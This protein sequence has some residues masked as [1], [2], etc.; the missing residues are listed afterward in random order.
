MSKMNLTLKWNNR[1]TVESFQYKRAIF[2]LNQMD[3]KY[4]NNFF[5]EEVSVSYS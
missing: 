5:F 3:L 1:L 2:V 4:F